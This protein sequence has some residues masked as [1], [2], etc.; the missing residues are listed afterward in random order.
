MRTAYGDLCG[1]RTRCACAGAGHNRR[2]GYARARTP[3]KAEVQREECKWHGPPAAA[4]ASPGRG[5]WQRLAG[6]GAHTVPVAAG[7]FNTC[8]V[9]FKWSTACWLEASK[10]PPMQFPAILPGIWPPY[11][12]TACA[13]SGSGLK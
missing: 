9:V 6:P 5:E 3:V 7:Y 8:D 12:E 10:V 2:D 11:P 13:V 4:P 1:A